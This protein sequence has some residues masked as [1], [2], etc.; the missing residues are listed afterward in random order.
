MSYQILP[1]II[2]IFAILGIVLI[3]LRHLPEASNSHK[4]EPKEPAADKTLIAKG[5][6]AQAI[7]KIRVGLSFSLKKV[8]N[9]MLEAKDLKPQ[10]N[11]GYKIR[12]IFG[13]HLPYFKKPVIL[14][15][16]FHEVKN[17]KYYLDMIKQQPKNLSHY[18]A[19]GKFYLEQE[20]T[21]DAKD[22]Y[23]YAVNHEP[24]NPDYQARLAYCYYQT[25]QFKKAAQA[26]QKSLALDSTQPN[27]YY[28]LGLSL[29]A[30]G[31]IV[32]AIRNLEQAINLEPSPKYYIS[33]SN[34]YI[35]SGNAAKAKH[36]LLTAKAKDPKNELI[37]AKLEKMK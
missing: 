35:K 21:A 4:Q 1:N 10:A 19:L 3:I 5:L 16:T 15:Q 9:F 26:Y 27:R 25:K 28:N 6:P 31:N 8:W 18:D 36:A 24:A 17:E 30:A 22:I 14:P 2:F 32:E 13:S 29:E 37:L 33:L 11:T 7:S 12:K 20:N 34:A 23:L